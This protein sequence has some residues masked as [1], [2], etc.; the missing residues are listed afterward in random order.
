MQRP[1]ILKRALNR[2]LDFYFESPG[3]LR[4]KD[5]QHGDWHEQRHKRTRLR[6]HHTI[7]TDPDALVVEVTAI[8]LRFDEVEEL[9]ARGDAASAAEIFARSTLRFTAASGHFPSL[10]A[11]TWSVR[12]AQESNMTALE[13]ASDLMDASRAI[14]GQIPDIATL[15]ELLDHEDE[16]IRSLGGTGALLAKR[17]IAA[18]WLAE[19]PDAGS[20]LGESILQTLQGGELQSF[21]LW[22]EALYASHP[23]PHWRQPLPGLKQ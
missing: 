21:W 5:P 15:L 19:G 23:D 17:T 9:V 14:S 20:A 3:Y 10:F 16:E 13:A 8:G 4:V 1:G 12:D 11:K 22:L 18:A 7:R 2:D 6:I